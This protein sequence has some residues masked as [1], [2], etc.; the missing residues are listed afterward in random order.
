ML[1]NKIVDESL[2]QTDECMGKLIICPEL[3][4]REIRRKVDEGNQSKKNNEELS[5][6]VLTGCYGTDGVIYLPDKIEGHPVTAIAPYAFAETKEEA[7]DL[8]W[9]SEEASLAADRH[10]ICA[11]EVV[12]VHLPRYV[13][14]VGRYAFYRCRN[15]SKLT[16]HDEIL[17]IGGG[18]LNGCRFQEVE[19]Y[20]H[21][22]GEQSALKSIV[23]EIRYE[24]HVR[25]YQ[26]K[27]DGTCK[28]WEILFP[29]HYEEAVENTPAR[30]L[31]T[32]HHG[33]GGYYRQC[34]YNR[35]LD[36]KKYDELLPRAVAEEDEETVVRLAMARLMYP[37][38][39]S[40]SAREAYEIYVRAH[41]EVT[42]RL[43]AEREDVRMARFLAAGGYWTRESLEYGIE[44][45]GTLKKTEIL[46][47]LMDERYRLF[48]KKRKTFEL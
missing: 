19:I 6:V 22:E 36:Y 29:E 8:V 16:L 21:H 1:E 40:E 28:M 43:V 18:A 4:Y 24:I 44:T 46:S 37:H 15:M 48:P 3:H 27:G 12:E 5:E 31:Y 33:A 9:V 20:F 41:M 35:E 42:V 7:E 2:P 25:M 10:R 26:D 14:E 11:A 34:F 13:R 17:E 47:V 38:K 30:I 39:L 45:A 23:D 32:S